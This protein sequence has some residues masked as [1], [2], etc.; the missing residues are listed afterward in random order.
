MITH[1]RAICI[2]PEVSGES[3]MLPVMIDWMRNLRWVRADTVLVPELPVNGR[4]V[5]LAVMTKSGTLSSFELKLGGFGRALEQASYNQLSF[6]RSWVVVGGMPRNENL[7]A[8]R[9]FG[10]GVIVCSYSTPRILL[11]PGKPDPDANLRARLQERMLR[12]G[13]TGV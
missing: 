1:S 4:R 7:L 6:D 9:T 10:I 3:R 5:D 13:G 11:R 12:M 8:A 2:Q